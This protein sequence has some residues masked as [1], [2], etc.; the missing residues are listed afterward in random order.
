MC[1]INNQKDDQLYFRE[2]RRIKFYLPM[3]G[4]KLNDVKMV[5]RVKSVRLQFWR[6]SSVN[7]FQ[8]VVLCHYKMGM[9]G[10]ATGKFKQF[11]PGN[12]S[13]ERRPGGPV[14]QQYIHAGFRFCQIQEQ[15]D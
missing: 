13:E 6:Q 15:I 4:V 14:C 8:K 10:S 7:Y 11:R 5:L 3:A 12:S 1:A 9:R 2:L